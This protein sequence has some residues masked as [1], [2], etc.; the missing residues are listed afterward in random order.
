MNQDGN[1]LAAEEGAT[2]TALLTELRD[3]IR[4]QPAGRPV[5]VGIDGVSA[6]GKTILADELASLLRRE[7][8]PVLRSGVDSYHHPPD[9]RYRRGADCPRGYYEDSFDLAAIR[10]DLLEP[11]APDYPSERRIRLGRFDFRS[12]SELEPEEHL[13]APD[14]ILIFEGVFLFRPELVGHWDVRVLVHIGFEESLRR[15]EQRDA[16]RFG[17]AERVRDR[18]RARYIPGQRHYLDAHRPHDRAHVVI[19]NHRPENP[20]WEWR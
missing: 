3:H 5:R 19:D 2:R 8:R 9:I 16:E 18:F 14:S 4:R 1:T 10:E 20:A 12:E 7:G 6:A 15:A 17:S 13:A 11:L